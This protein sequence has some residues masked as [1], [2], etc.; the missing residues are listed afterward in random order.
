MDPTSRLTR[1]PTSL[2]QGTISCNWGVGV[3]SQGSPGS[4]GL[5]LEAQP[6]RTVEALDGA[7]QGPGRCQKPEAAGE[8]EGA[9][10]AE[11]DRA[12]PYL[13]SL[14]EQRPGDT[15][16]PVSP[17]KMR[18]IKTK[19]GDLHKANLIHCKGLFSMIITFLYF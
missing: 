14:C 12:G 8:G 5:L 17:S 3:L 1:A 9:S 10:V 18:K 15:G 13:G 19:L 2:A 6:P 16:A 11:A 7:R 4:Q